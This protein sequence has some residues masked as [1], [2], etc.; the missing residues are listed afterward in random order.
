MDVNRKRYKR[1]WIAAFRKMTATC[2]SD[3]LQC[4]IASDDEFYGRLQNDDAIGDNHDNETSNIS[5]ELTARGTASDKCSEYSEKTH[6][7][8]EYCSWKDYEYNEFDTCSSSDTDS[9]QMDDSVLS[10]SLAAWVREFSV[11]QN[12]VDKLLNI[13]QLAGHK[14]PLTARSLFKTTKH[15]SISEKSGMQYVYLDIKKQLQRFVEAIP[16]RL[17]ELLDGKLEISLNID[18]L[19][20][21]KSSSTCVWPILCAVVNVKPAKVFPVALACGH[22]RF[23]IS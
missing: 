13:L 18:G 3:S 19:P 15:V 11:K 6:S 8:M 10:D 14:V 1:T 22:M 2:S 9:E 20:L 17:L 16:S 5:V 4:D 7:D 12:A 23:R 21:F